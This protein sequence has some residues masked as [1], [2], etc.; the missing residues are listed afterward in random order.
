MG[1]HCGLT[2]TAEQRQALTMLTRSADR[3]EADRARAILWTLDGQPAPAIGIAL[4]VRPDRVRKWRVLFAAGGVEA[5]RARSRTGRPGDKGI[6]AL[7]WAQAILAEPG[8]T[9]WTLPRLKAEIARRS[10]IA[11]SVSRLSI[12]LRQKG[13]LRGAARATAS[14]AGRTHKRSNAPGFASPC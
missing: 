8:R 13:A 6:A 9:V 10:G 12:L 11:I 2:A 4:G 3:G 7:A 14:R 1:R 5:L